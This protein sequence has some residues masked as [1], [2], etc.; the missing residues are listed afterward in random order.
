MPRL[1]KEIKDFRD[2]ELTIFLRT[3]VAENVFTNTPLLKK[4]CNLYGI[5]ITKVMEKDSDE[6][7]KSKNYFNALRK[8]RKSVKEIKI[9]RAKRTLYKQ[10]NLWKEKQAEEKNPSNKEPSN[11]EPSNK[12]CETISETISETLSE[13]ISETILPQVSFAM[14]MG[15][16]V[17]AEENVLLENSYKHIKKINSDFEKTEAERE[18]I[19]ND[20]TE[21]R[22]MKSALF[23]KA[24]ENIAFE[25]KLKITEEIANLSRIQ[26]NLRESLEDYK[27]YLEIYEIKSRITER[28]RS[29]IIL[30]AKTLKTLIEAD[31]LA[32]I[33]GI[34]TSHKSFENK[35][36]MNFNILPV[37]GND[38]EILET[39]TQS[40][41]E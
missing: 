24:K 16:E 40:Q 18:Q 33:N 4:Y 38:E 15:N 31:Q 22:Q 27:L 35:S 41:K 36:E 20:L 23:E 8:K 25:D 29:N 5:D 3:N 34:V 19:L 21:L 1:S 9:E 28:E 7:I 11:K 14:K 12:E 2:M 6:Y 32:K 10:K 37:K 39:L 26:A 17:F 13:T 30:V